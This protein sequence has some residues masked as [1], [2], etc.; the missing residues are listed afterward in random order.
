MRE[1]KY[2]EILNRVVGITPENYGED[3]KW[4]PK[5]YPA[6]IGPI[7]APVSQHI[8]CIVDKPMIIV[9]E[10]RVFDSLTNG[11]TNV[12]TGLEVFAV[13]KNPCRYEVKKARYSARAISKA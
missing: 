5:K 11:V 9:T 1:R 8:N 3:S 7:Y 4:I 6:R 2:I 12:L 13:R 10:T